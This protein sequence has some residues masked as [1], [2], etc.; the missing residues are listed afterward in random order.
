[1]E[2]RSDDNAPGKEQWYYTRE[3]WKHCRPGLIGPPATYSKSYVARVRQAVTKSRNKKIRRWIRALQIP[4]MTIA[5]INETYRRR[6][7]LI[8]NQW[9]YELNINPFIHPLCSYSNRFHF[10]YCGC[11]VSRVM[12]NTEFLYNIKK[13]KKRKKKFGCTNNSSKNNLTQIFSR[14]TAILLRNREFMIYYESYH[15]FH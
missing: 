12:A 6:A 7:G 2:I 9:A 11:F 4:C 15:V 3:Q 5:Y 1:M 13:K 8:G 14:F 10:V